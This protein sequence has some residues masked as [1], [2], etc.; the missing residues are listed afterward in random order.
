[1]SLVE[2]TPTCSGKVRLPAGDSDRSTGSERRSIIAVDV[3]L[4]F[5]SVDRAKSHFVCRRPSGRV[6]FQFTNRMG[7][8]MRTSFGRSLV[9]VGAI[10]LAL[11]FVSCFGSKGNPGST[12]TQTSATAAPSTTGPTPTAGPINFVV[13]GAVNGQTAGVPVTTATL[14]CTPLSAQNV[15]VDWSGLLAEPLNLCRLAVWQGLESQP[16]FGSWLWPA[17]LQPLVIAFGDRLRDEASSVKRSR[18]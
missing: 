13:T 7:D 5:V 14:R 15:M 16:P 9:I 12:T 10:S 18:V 3:Q 2:L 17:L 1:M 4:R 11:V 6:G 8:A